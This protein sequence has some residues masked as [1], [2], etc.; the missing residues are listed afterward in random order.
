MLGLA[1]YDRRISP[2]SQSLDDHSICGH[3]PVRTVQ[4]AAELPLPRA[5]CGVIKDNIKE[6]TEISHLIFSI[7]AGLNGER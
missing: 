3:R 1:V 6:V 5:A 7:F 4:P 2:P